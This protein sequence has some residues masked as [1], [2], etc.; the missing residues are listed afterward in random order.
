MVY[1][2]SVP[3][4]TPDTGIAASSGIQDKKNKNE[5]LTAVALVAGVGAVVVA[6]ALPDG[7]DAAAILTLE[8]A[9]LTFRLGTCRTRQRGR[10]GSDG[11]ARSL[12]RSFST[13]F[14]VHM[15]HCDLLTRSFF[16]APL[17]K[18][19]GFIRT[20]WESQQD[21]TTTRVTA[22]LHEGQCC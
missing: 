6:V 7:W 19:T 13:T 1:T 10:N 20:S 22:A 15:L 4:Q 11:V 9:G 3:V 17:P 12:A 2:R 8:L 16:G 18:P 14:I 21:F 5:T